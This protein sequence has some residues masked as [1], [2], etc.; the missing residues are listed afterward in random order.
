MAPL[1]AML[2][3]IER[4]IN[5]AEQS[6]LELLRSLNLAKMKQQNL[7]MSTN[8]KIVDDPF[9]PIAPMPSRTKLLVLVAAVIGFVIVAFLILML[10]Y[11]DTSVKSPERI[12]K[13]TKLKLAGAYP[14]F[15]PGTQSPEFKNAS[16]RLL[17]II[18][19]NIK[20]AIGHQSLYSAEKPYFVLIFSTKPKVGKTTLATNL[21]R[22]LRTYG[23]K[24]L[25]LNYSKESE[26]EEDD[27]NYAVYYKIDNKFVEIKHIK[28][29]LKNNYLRQENY[30]Y[31][32]IFL[33]IPA[34][35]YNSFPLDLMETVDFSLLVVKAQD[36]WKKA[37][38]SALNTLLE[39]SREKPMIILNQAE[40]Y[41]LED[42]MHD[43]PQQRDRSIR[44]RLKKIITYPSKV[45]IRVK[46]D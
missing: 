34:I 43:I 19:Q 7:E 18:I 45:R 28:D 39:V 3:R 38:Q 41:A 1:G 8:I 21:I 20:L 30:K 23:E 35:I 24:V 33:E 26:G 9:F 22:K 10:E 16:E 5:V 4:E 46:V 32:Y 17:E 40:V 27:F 44:R 15:G 29:L 14:K 12:K 31:D 25:Y 42:I 37:D 6:Y 36:H 13:A 2:K 11:F